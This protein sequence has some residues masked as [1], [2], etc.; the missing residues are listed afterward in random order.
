MRLP[1]LAHG[2]F[3]AMEGYL[4]AVL[5][6]DTTYPWSLGGEIARSGYRALVDLVTG[7]V[8]VMMADPLPTADRLRDVIRSVAL[9]AGVRAE[10]RNALP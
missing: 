9:P 2:N 4:P 7:L 5:A 10:L 8:G 6:A 3:N 1:D